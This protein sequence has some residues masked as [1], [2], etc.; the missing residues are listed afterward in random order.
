MT[1]VP[2]DIPQAWNVAVSEK[3]SLSG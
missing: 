3:H 2:V 1:F